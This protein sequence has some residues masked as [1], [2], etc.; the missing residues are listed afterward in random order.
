MIL[1]ALKGDAVL[2]WGDGV[3]GPG[4]DAFR[5]LGSMQ[6]EEALGLVHVLQ[7]EKC[8]KLSSSSLFKQQRM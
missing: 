4:L 7:S 8:S 1:G 5:A 2:A 6:S 3:Q